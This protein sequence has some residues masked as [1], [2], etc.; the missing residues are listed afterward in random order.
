MYSGRTDCLCILV[1]LALCWSTR[2]LAVIGELMGE[3]MSSDS[4]RV[5]NGGTTT[6][7]HGPDAALSIED[8]KLE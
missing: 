8:G 1:G 5:Y 4:I 7:D 2:V 6:S 3:T